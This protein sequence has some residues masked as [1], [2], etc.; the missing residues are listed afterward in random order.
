MLIVGGLVG[1][2]L[3]A[4]LIAVLL[5]RGEGNDKQEAAK[6]TAQ[7]E[8]LPASKNGATPAPQTTPRTV[9]PGRTTISHEQG[10]TPFGE[11]ERAAAVRGQAQELSSQLRT[12]HKQA[13][14]LEQHLGRLSTAFEQAMLR[15]QVEQPTLVGMPA[16]QS[17]TRP[18]KD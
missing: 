16:I 10:L 4:L 11:L 18:F 3:V 14:D 15:E 6:K 17:S 12:L 5:I 13:S 2:G 1:I 8:A 9:Q 7:A